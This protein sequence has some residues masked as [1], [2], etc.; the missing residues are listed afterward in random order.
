[1][2][3]Y[4]LSVLGQA[5][6]W[7]NLIAALPWGEAH[8]VDCRDWNVP[9]PSV[10]L[11]LEGDSDVHIFGYLESEEDLPPRVALHSPF[12]NPREA[13]LYVYGSVPAYVNY[14]MGS[15]WRARLQPELVNS[16]SGKRYEKVIRRTSEHETNERE[17]CL[18][19]RKCG[20]RYVRSELYAYGTGPRGPAYIFGWPAGGGVMILRDMPLGHLDSWNS[21]SIEIQNQRGAV[22]RETQKR[23]VKACRELVH[24][25][26][27]EGVCRVIEEAGGQFYANVGD[28]PEAM[29]SRLTVRSLQ[30]Q[31]RPEL[32][33]RSSDNS[34][35]V[36][37]ALPV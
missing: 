14:I 10:R 27:M 30:V 36:A 4:I 21:L 5:R 12:G 32:T 9:D 24:H 26:T 19:M 34:R 31:Q 13:R 33:I 25:E 28:C 6:A 37:M 18:R 16:L 11:R 29:R 23:Y 35:P 15:D 20:A 22:L 1:M 17:H 8:S 2:L 7:D 3:N